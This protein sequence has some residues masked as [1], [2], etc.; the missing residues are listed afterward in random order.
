MRGVLGKGLGVFLLGFRAPSKGPP[1][2]I[3]A[4]NEPFW[5]PSGSL[6]K[7]VLIPNGLPQTPSF[8]HRSGY[9]D[10]QIPRDDC[11]LEKH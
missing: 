9:T 5:P 11:P 7:G 4:T 10:T 2:A 6:F 3:F 1:G 8:D